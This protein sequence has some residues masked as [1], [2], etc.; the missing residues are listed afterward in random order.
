MLRWAHTHLDAIERAR[1]WSSSSRGGQARLR[2]RPTN[3]TRER[4][5]Q[6]EVL[7][8]VAALRGD[9]DDVAAVADTLAFD[10]KYTS[11]VIAWAPET[12]RATR[13]STGCSTSSSRAPGPGW[14]RRARAGSS[15]RLQPWSRLQASTSGP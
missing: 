12:S 8:D 2:P 6:G 11:G 13:T 1:R 4:D 15:G 5:S 14:P 3:L 9:P 10:H 7:D